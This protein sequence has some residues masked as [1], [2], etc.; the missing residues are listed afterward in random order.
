MFDP[1][2]YP[3]TSNIP[4]QLILTLSFPVTNTLVSSPTILAA[5]PSS[6]MARRALQSWTVYDQRV[7]SGMC[8]SWGTSLPVLGLME[9]GLG[10]KWVE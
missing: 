2:S 7:R 9:G 5:S 6:W 4:Q 8:I 10:T 3:N 1:P